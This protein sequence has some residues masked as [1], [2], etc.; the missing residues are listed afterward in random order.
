MAIDLHPSCPITPTGSAFVA[1]QL[2]RSSTAFETATVDQPRGLEEIASFGRT[3]VVRVSVDDDVEV[4]AE[5]SITMAEASQH[6][7][8]ATSDGASDGLAEIPLEQNASGRRLC[9]YNSSLVTEAQL[10]SACSL[11]MLASFVAC[12]VC[13]RILIFLDTLLRT[14]QSKR[15][16]YKFVVVSQF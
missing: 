13:F 2:A 8:A 6:N 4:E 15:T 5:N 14:R 11:T 16:P 10:L 9:L 7:F 3:C 12:S 1:P